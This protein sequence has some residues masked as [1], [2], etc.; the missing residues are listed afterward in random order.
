MR[1]SVT[2]GLRSVMQKRTPW[3]SLECVRLS[4]DDGLAT[5][6][7]VARYP[8]ATTALRVRR[9]PTL[10]PLEAWCISHGVT[11]ALV[12]GFYVRRTEV[13]PVPS[14]TG[15]PLGELR[16]D[17]ALHP[18]VPFTPPWGE[19]RACLS[20]VGSE[21]RIAR[22]DELPEHPSG[23]LLQAGPLLVRGGRAVSGDE[24]G[25]SVA[26][27]QF[28]SDITEGRHPR[29][30]LGSDGESLIALA[31]DGRAEDEAGLTIDEL[32][33]AMAG[34]GASEALNLDGGGS[35]SLVCAGR[36]CNHPRE[37]HEVSVPGGRAIATALVFARR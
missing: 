7:Y 5:T 10:T 25:F 3:R 37:A 14:V 19:R 33:A 34:L 26:A 36:L 4:L 35:T 17:G 2:L 29:A 11:E 27:D 16:L 12:G 1:G 31:C 30:A 6:A 20:V 9:L 13:P 22:R 32:A 28:D 15:L 8:L 23:D 18:F 24:E 21:V